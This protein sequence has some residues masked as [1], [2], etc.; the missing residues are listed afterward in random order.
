[1]SKIFV[2]HTT[3][4]SLCWFCTTDPSEASK[5]R[6]EGHTVIELDVEPWRGRRKQPKYVV[7][8]EHADGTA[9][10]DVEGA[11]GLFSKYSS[12]PHPIWGYATGVKRVD[13]SDARTGRRY[14]VVYQN[15]RGNAF[16]RVDAVTILK[17]FGNEPHAH[18]GYAV[19]IEEE[20]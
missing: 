5:Y 16:P 9:Q 19:G 11:A 7:T 6:S 17:R 13:P 1:M 3:H 8:Y 18:L 4:G 10:Y 12:V 14:R 15:G 2:T 20:S